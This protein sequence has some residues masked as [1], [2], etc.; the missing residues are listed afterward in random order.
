MVELAIWNFHKVVK[1]L[2]NTWII[3]LLI[4]FFSAELHIAY[5]I[6]LYIHI[7]I[8][9]YLPRIFVLYI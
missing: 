8:E 2:Q 3:Y 7:T 4:M 5:I 6:Q 9:Q 1:V